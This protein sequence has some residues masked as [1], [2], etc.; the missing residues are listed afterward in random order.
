MIRFCIGLL[1]FLTIETGFAQPVT[2]ADGNSYETVTIGS[3]VWLNA[4]LRTTHF[5]NGDSI[6]TTQIPNQNISAEAVPIYQWSWNGNEDLALVYGRLYTWHV[7]IDERK[8]CP[9]G[10]HVPSKTEFETLELFLGGKE[11]AGGRLKEAGLDH[12]ESP[13]S[14]ATNETGFNGLPNGHR[15]PVGEFNGLGYVSDTWSSTEGNNGAWDFDLNHDTSATSSYDDPKNWGFAIRCLSDL[16]K[17]SDLSRLTFFPVPVTNYLIVDCKDFYNLH[18]EFFSIQGNILAA[19]DFVTG[20]NLLNLESFP[21]GV[22]VIRVSHSLSSREFK[23]VK[24]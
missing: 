11:V 16:P 23:I 2:D 7:V 24:I 19:G 17:E 22:Y 4:N 10:W 18:Y 21:N 3:Q 15:N 6:P 20:E 9:A 1:F 5:L 12:W 13:N 8:V 14:G